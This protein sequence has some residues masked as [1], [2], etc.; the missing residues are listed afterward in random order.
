MNIPPEGCVGFATTRFV[1]ANSE[2]EAAEIALQLV[3]ETVAAEEAFAS[4]PKPALAVDMVA[5][6]RSPF[7]RSRPNSGYSFIGRDAT[8]EDALHIERQ[9][10][11]GWWL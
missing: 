10:G 1:R 8:P 9:A 11:A 3:S 2:S 7:K 5:R 4:S 6:V